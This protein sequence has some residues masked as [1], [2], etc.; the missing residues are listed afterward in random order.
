MAI[1]RWDPHRDLRQIRE[2]MNRLFDDVAARDPRT[3][4]ADTVTSTGWKPP[5]DVFEDDDRFVL[6]VD[7][8]GLS[9]A[10][11]EIEVEDGTLVLRGGRKWDPAVPRESYLRTDRPHGR[12][13]L[14]LALPPTIDRQKIRASHTAGVLEVVLPKSRVDTPSRI[15]VQVQ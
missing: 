15:K 5:L 9:K 8:P 4:A 3:G 2:R 12:F 1:Q 13:V 6:R 14:Q 11:V 10:D 7:L